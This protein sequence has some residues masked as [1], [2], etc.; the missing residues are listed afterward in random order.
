MNYTNQ[1]RRVDTFR[2]ALLVGLGAQLLAPALMAQEAKAPE[3]LDKMVIIG[4]RIPTAEIETAQPVEVYNRERI[5]KMAVTTVNELL[6]R[7]PQANAAGLNGNNGGTGFAAGATGV[8]LRGLGLNATLV[9]LN[10]RRVSAYGF[11]NDGTSAFVDL[12]SL[13]LEAIESVEILTAGN[14]A[15]YGADAI[16][17]VINIKTK[18]TYRGGELSFYYGNTQHTDYGTL[19]GSITFGTGNDKT[20]VMVIADYYHQND[21]FNRDRPFSS[22]VNLTPLG[23][24]NLG[25]SRGYPGRFEV[26]VD[27]PGLIGTPF[28]DAAGGRTVRL[29]PPKT[30]DGHAAPAD[31]H[32]YTGADSYNYNQNSQA[33]PSSE[34]MGVYGNF[35]HKVFDEKLQLFGEFAFRHVEEH[36]ELAPSPLDII[37]NGIPLGSSD[38]TAGVVTPGNGLTIPAT[39]PFNPFGADITDGRYRFFEAGNRTYDFATDAV[40]L[41]GGLRGELNEHFSYETAVL[42]NRGQTVNT[43]QA[44]GIQ[45]IQNALNDPNPATALNL[46][47]GPNAPNNPATIN[48]LKVNAKHIG[49]TEILNWDAKAFGKAFTLPGGDVGYA[50]GVEYRTE[51]FEDEPDQIQKDGGIVGQSRSLA[52]TGDR[53]VTS[54]Y[55]E[56]R[57]PIT[58]KDWNAAPLYRV[59]ITAAGRFDHYNDFGDSTV[60][61]IGLQ[62]RPFNEDLMFRGSYAE[63][64]RPASLQQLFN[65]ALDSYTGTP[66]TDPLRGTDE[67]EINLK[68]GGNPNLE[69]ETATQWTAGMVLSPSQVKGLRVSVDWLR[70][71]RVNEIGTTSDFFGYDYLAVQPGRYK[72]GTYEGDA[73]FLAANP[74]LPI[75]QIDPATGQP[76]GPLQSLNDNYA[77]IGAT[78]SDY[79]D[80]QVTYEL[81][82]DTAGTWTFDNT[83][84]YLL[85]YDVL[86]PATGDYLPQAGGIFYSGSDALPKWRFTSSLFWSYQK[87]EAGVIANYI[88][89]VDYDNP[90]SG[91]PATVDGFLTFDLQASYKFPWDVRLTVGVNNV[92]DEDPPLYVGASSNAFAYL[93]SLHSPLGRS[94]Y[95]RVTKSF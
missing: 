33:L 13:P 94:Y 51:T 82:T 7:V 72:R 79:I 6:Q 25:S 76:A 16:A 90:V 92:A 64:F 11:A 21:L 20:D 50:A 84:T 17:G 87:L 67:R 19:K 75:P 45:A 14:S 62:W 39:N 48:S 44:L 46:F 23:G 18:Q 56:T 73:A 63:N 57:I 42:F 60:P 80:F 70:I 40:R 35:A 4:S 12:N 22:L 26:P 52:N 86:D 49:T 38:V 93:S 88:G 71:K 55:V 28:Y 65:Q 29:V 8:S 43:A 34:R 37:G 66:F 3:E 59:D 32:L 58:G 54:A 81:A 2:R 36:V 31:Y 68:S 89:S 47:T 5:D 61:T 83:V 95:F 41:L 24:L 53:N 15:V 10:G 27:A 1:Q 30:T 78:K 77:N 69:P 9:L 85:N 74:G 91:D